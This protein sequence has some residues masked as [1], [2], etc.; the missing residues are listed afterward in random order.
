M[1]IRIFP[2]LIITSVLFAAG[3]AG[4]YW[5]A[6]QRLTSS[7]MSAE[8]PNNAA[9]TEKKALYWYDPMFPQQKFDQP[10]KSPFMDMQLVPRYGGEAGDS[11]GVSIDSSVTQNL[12]IRLATATLGSLN[13]EIQA[14]GILTLNDRDVAVVQARS[15]GFV[16]RVY[17][18]APQD[19]IPAGAPLAEI[20]VPEWSSAQED[21]LALRSSGANNL[22]AAAKQ[23][24]RLSGMPAGLIAEVVRSGK[25]HPEWT[26]TSPIGG[27]IEQLDIR[28]G[29]TVSAGMTLARINGL[30]S[31]WL[32]IAVPEAQATGLAANQAVEARLP[33]L[34]GEVIK[35]R[36]SAILPKADMQSRTLSVRVELDNPAGKLRPGQ[37]ANVRLMQ[38]ATA[39]A[40]LIPSEAVI[41][42]GR[43]ALVMLASADGRYQATEVTLGQES[44]NQVEI[45]Q[46]LEAGQQVVASGQFL[47]DSEASLRGIEI[48]ALDGSSRAVMKPALHQAEGQIVSLDTTSI[49]LAHGPFKTLSMPSMTMQF[50]V[51]APQLLEGLQAGDSVRVGV[52]E[53]DSGLVIEHIEP[54]KMEM[55][56]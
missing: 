29:M 3:A 6:N 50:P 1:N 18:R 28:Q 36:I 25:P 21:Y 43:R 39:P 8:M 33:G 31:V 11:A 12:G 40:I 45:T 19:V 38:S 14:A 52:S 17:A 10:G 20:Y 42:S 22:I 54:V 9:S 46:G 30:S 41:R 34:A 15:M 55:Q 26:V 44:G 47:L 5:F 7:A 32:D 27:V 53:G 51:A 16:E 23:R 37:T 49:T 35:G 48:T 24:M 56:P 4:G 13:P 2:T